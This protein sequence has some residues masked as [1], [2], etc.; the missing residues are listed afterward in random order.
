MKFLFQEDNER[1]TKNK[2]HKYN[3]NNNKRINAF[4]LLILELFHDTCCFHLK[5]ILCFPTEL[6][7][8]DHFPYLM[9]LSVIYTSLYIYCVS[10]PLKIHTPFA[11]LQHEHDKP[12]SLL[13]QNNVSV[14]T[15]TIL[16]H[17]HPYQHT[18]FSFS[19]KVKKYPKLLAF[20]LSFIKKRIKIT[21]HLQILTHESPFLTIIP[22]QLFYH[23][24]IISYC[25]RYL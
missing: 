22:T 19:I 4:S 21:S 23:T 8:A 6:S 10:R 20:V 9:L 5:Y 16:L 14:L 13:R 7:N 25:H 11:F 12:F 24:V 17:K 1:R 18:H 2:Q 15:L 3:N